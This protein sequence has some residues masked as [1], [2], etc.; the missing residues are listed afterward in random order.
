[1]KRNTL[2]ITGIALLLS[3]VAVSPFA[4][5]PGWGRSRGYSHMM[6]YDGWGPG[7][8]HRGGHGHGQE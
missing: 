7:W 6:G 3:I 2:I 4:H 1:M 8:H 5:G